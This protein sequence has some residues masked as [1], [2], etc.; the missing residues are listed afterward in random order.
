M[1]KYNVYDE[2][3]GEF[4]GD[5]DMHATLV[6]YICRNGSV[7]F[8]TF[9]Y[10]MCFLE[11]KKS[12]ILFKDALTEMAFEFC[13]I[14][15]DILRA[16]GCFDG[17]VW[18]DGSKMTSQSLMNRNWNRIEG[19][20]AILKG[21]IQSGKTNAMIAFAI[22]NIA[23]G[24][25]TL[26]VL[27]RCKSDLIQIKSRIEGINK[28][29]QEKLEQMQVEDIPYE[30]EYIDSTFKMEEFKNAMTG[31]RPRIIV[32]LGN[33]TQLKRMSK[34][35]EELRKDKKKVKYN[36]V[37]DECDLVDNE[38]T[39]TE[40][41]LKLIKKRARLVLLVS[42][43]IL[44]NVMKENIEKGCLFVLPRPDTVQ[45][46][47][48]KDSL[49]YYCGIDTI[50]SFMNISSESK[51][52]NKIA[53][54]PFKKIPK[55]DKFLQFWS[56]LRPTIVK[57]VKVP[58]IMLLNIGKTIAPQETLFSWMRV[59]LY[60]QS[61]SILYNG[62]GLV[63]SHCQLPNRSFT[64]CNAKSTYNDRCKTHTFNDLSISDL[65]Q[66]FK[67]NGGIEKFP[68]IVTIAGN[69]AC[70]GL[71]FVSS[72]VGQMIYECKQG[73][74]SK[75]VPWYTNYIFYIA[76][77][78]TDQPEL[79]Q[80]VGRICAVTSREMRYKITLITTPETRKAIIKA[81]HLQEDLI[82]EA[83][84]SH[85]EGYY[86]ETIQNRPIF[87]KK[88]V[89]GRSVTKNTKCQ[90]NWVGDYKLDPGRCISEYGYNVELGEL[91]K[92]WEVAIATTTATAT[93]GHIRKIISSTIKGPIA[94]QMYTKTIHAMVK[95]GKGVWHTR[96]TVISMLMNDN[97]NWKT[98]QQYNDQLSKFANGKKFM[99]MVDDENTPGLLMM[100]KDKN[101]EL[102]LN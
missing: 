102:R 84:R 5:V 66:W 69:L 47:D 67:D 33:P 50:D 88:R 21:H 71:S 32:M 65:Y 31:Y 40:E 85:T 86:R 25:S 63:V 28:I 55:I 30:I 64:I 68:R 89:N 58:K 14:V 18:G 9:R 54:D 87:N 36:I 57:G 52:C 17:V 101:W 96:P 94:T 77:P 97:A 27:R 23:L 51:P 56:R 35:I 70:R 26:I 43:T 24:R 7:K 3:I 59:K 73:I 12:K 92:K 13:P 38:G 10:Q 20:T 39:Q 95:L 2:K 4:I 83:R 76:S 45:A 46:N 37:V 34:G 99:S 62:N 91:K 19:N 41:Q 48:G 16:M 44:D 61:V 60:K 6:K 72:D 11:D 42:A 100:K 98:Y 49:L 8:A 79:L 1:K 90:L 29:V 93:V 22:A 78:T 80:N 75:I 74:R 15:K 53:D 82:A 81:F